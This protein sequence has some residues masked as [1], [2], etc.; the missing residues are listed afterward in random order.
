MIVT[1]GS[2]VLLTQ[3][4]FWFLVFFRDLFVKLIRFR[5]ISFLFFH[6]IS[7]R[8]RTSERRFL[9]NRIARTASRRFGG[10]DIEKIRRF[11]KKIGRNGRPKLE[12][13]PF[14]SPFYFSH[15]ISNHL[16]TSKSRFL[17][18]RL[19]QTALR[20]F[21]CVGIEKIRRLKKKFDWN[22]R[23]KPD[24]WPFEVSQIRGYLQYLRMFQ[25]VVTSGPNVLSRQFFFWFLVFLRDLF[26]KLIPF[27]RIS[28][29]LFHRVST[30]KRRFLKNRFAQTA[31]RRFRR[32]D[33]EKIRGFKKKI[34][35]N[36][37]PKPALWPFEFP[38][39]TATFNL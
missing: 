24:L 35:W 11:E 7:T 39:F 32:V 3:F 37:Q 28:L 20:Q 16:R 10:V 31:W 27:H 8:R 15:L 12:L 14:E 25:T 9:K 5:W 1:F 13:R 6:H 17:E 36:G 26:E 19:A 2:N 4:F 23:P 30:S 34:A 21:G 29:L 18:N 33:I 22:G 38:F